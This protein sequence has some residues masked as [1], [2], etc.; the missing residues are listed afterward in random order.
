MGETP[1]TTVHTMVGN[2]LR[3]RA[4]MAN[5][6]CAVAEQEAH[7]GRLLE[8]TETVRSVRTHLAEVSVLL[9]GNTSYLPYGTLRET[10]ELLAGL[11][12]RIGEI[13]RVLGPQTIH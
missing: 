3:N 9:S 12:E 2:T 11:D 4:M 1:M 6:L 10:S 13:E 5:A 8:A 7:A